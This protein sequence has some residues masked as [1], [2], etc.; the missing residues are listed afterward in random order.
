MESAYVL[1]SAFCQFMKLNE[2]R[3]AAGFHLC[4][5]EGNYNQQLPGDLIVKDAFLLRCNEIRRSGAL[6]ALWRYSRESVGT[7][8]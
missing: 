3:K 8:N 6:T 5:E 4:D 7:V 2:N 1:R